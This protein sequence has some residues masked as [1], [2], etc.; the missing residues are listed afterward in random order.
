MQTK[1]VRLSALTN[2]ADKGVSSHAVTEAD[3]VAD[4]GGSPRAQLDA[5]RAVST[6]RLSYNAHV[7][8]KQR[9]KNLKRLAKK[10]L[11]CPI[12]HGVEGCDHT[13]TERQ[14]AWGGVFE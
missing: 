12:C 6:Q 3:K 5:A 2:K 7:G 9:R 14:N 8:E 13:V 4:A 10:F 1:H 11:P